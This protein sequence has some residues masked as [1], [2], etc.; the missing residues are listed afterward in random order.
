MRIAHRGRHRAGCRII[1][2]TSG[3]QAATSLCC[4][5]TSV[6]WWPRATSCGPSRR[7]ET[8]LPATNTRMT[9][10]FLIP[11]LT[12]NPDETAPAVRDIGSEDAFGQRCPGNRIARVRRAGAA[13]VDRPAE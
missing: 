5:P 4:P 3:P 1:T 12:L 8:P 6:T 13:A 2:W 9:I 11:E 7:P 10:T